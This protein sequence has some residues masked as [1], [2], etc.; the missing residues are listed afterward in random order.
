[1]RR[2]N[3]QPSWSGNLHHCHDRQKRHLWKVRS[4]LLIPISWKLGWLNYK[5][6]NYSTN[7]YWDSTMC[8]HSTRWRLYSDDKNKYEF[9]FMRFSP[10]EKSPVFILLFFPSL[11]QMGWFILEEVM[12]CRSRGRERIFLAEGWWHTDWLEEAADFVHNFSFCHL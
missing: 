6:I 8:R 12:G 3:C 4:V 7:I 2:S 5:F 10:S 1:M 9:V 11:Y